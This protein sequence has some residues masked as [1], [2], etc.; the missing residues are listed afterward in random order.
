MLHILFQI[1]TEVYVTTQGA[2][3]NKML[4]KEELKKTDCSNVDPI[5]SVEK[6]FGGGGRWKYN[7]L[8]EDFS[9]CSVLTGRVER[10]EGT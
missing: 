10:G 5:R 2:W 6:V 3:L 7:P 1:F 4:N 9:N 8:V